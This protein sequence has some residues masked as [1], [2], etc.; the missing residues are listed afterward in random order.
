MTS[1]DV[2]PTTALTNAAQLDLAPQ[3]TSSCRF[4]SSIFTDQVSLASLPVCRR[5]DIPLKSA[6]NDSDMIVTVLD[7]DSLHFLV[8]PCRLCYDVN[9]GVFEEIHGAH[10]PCVRR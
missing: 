9:E 1:D 10:C 7:D 5:L 3:A 8:D 6:S 2:S 4:N